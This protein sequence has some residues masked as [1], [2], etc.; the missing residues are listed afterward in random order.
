MRLTGY[1]A[2]FCRY[3][4]N[5]RFFIID[6]MIDVKIFET[7][8]KFKKITDYLTTFSPNTNNV[9]GDSRIFTVYSLYERGV[10]RM[11]EA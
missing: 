9:K 1:E 7:I 11:V 6:S 4:Y 5:R 2:V 3:F 10:S 8:L